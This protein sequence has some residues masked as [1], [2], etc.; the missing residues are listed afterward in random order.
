MSACYLCLGKNG[1]LLNCLQ[2]CYHEHLRTGEKVRLIV[3]QEFAPILDGFSYVERIVFPGTQDELPRAMK[4]FPKATV[5]QSWMNPDQSRQ[6]SSYEIEAWRRAGKLAAFGTTPLI[7]DQRDREREAKHCEHFKSEKPLILICTQSPSSPF[8]WAAELEKAVHDTFSGTHQLVDISL[9]HAE[10][11]YDLLGLFDRAQLLITIDTMPLHLARASRIPM[12][13]IVNDVGTGATPGPWTASVPPPQAKYTLRYSD[14]SDDSKHATQCV[15]SEAQEVFR[16]NRSRIIHAVQLH[17]QTERHKRAEQSWAGLFN[18]NTYEFSLTR[19]RTSK[20]IGDKRS[21][22]YLK[23]LFAFAMK[24]AKPDDIVFWSNDDNA[25]SPDLPDFLR[26]HV[27]IYGASTF[28][29]TENTPGIHCGREAAAFTVRWLRENLNR[30]PDF[31]LCSAGFDIGLA[32][33]IR[34]QRGIITTP[35]NLTVDFWPADVGVGYVMHEAHP[36]A[37]SG[38]NENSP[39]NAHNRRL[40]AEFQARYLP[41]VKERLA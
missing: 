37:W 32:A 16:I 39:S 13:A 40:L 14:F 26:K 30:I 20:A 23:D 6:T 28:R 9:H 1:D 41:Q 21:L 10:R 25:L 29:R 36:S 15:I 19:H 8:R 11:A 4:L 18:E 24:G 38:A 27:P 3:G 31:I 17:G 33:L 12:I 22:P 35:Q 2:I 34:L 5:L 7:V